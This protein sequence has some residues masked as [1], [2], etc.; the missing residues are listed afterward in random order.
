MVSITL[1]SNNNNNCEH[2]LMLCV[3]TYSTYGY[4][5]MTYVSCV[6]Q[7]LLPVDELCARSLDTVAFGLWIIQCEPA[8]YGFIRRWTSEESVYCTRRTRTRH[9][10]AVGYG[11]L[12]FAYI[13]D[14]SSLGLWLCVYSRCQLYRMTAHH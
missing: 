5:P 6:V 4:E 9:S 2:L 8:I 10:A 11:P 12:P 3:R 7:C 14:I 13:S 1:S